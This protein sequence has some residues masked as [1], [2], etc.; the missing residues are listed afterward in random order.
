MGVG[1][2]QSRRGVQHGFRLFAANVFW[3]SLNLIVSYGIAFVTSIVVARSLGPRGAGIVSYLT[4]LTDTG[5]L[6]TGLG[7][8]RALERFL[9]E[10]LGGGRPDLLSPVLWQCFTAIFRVSLFTGVLCALIASWSLSPKGEWHPGYF[11]IVPVLVIGGALWVATQAASRGLYDFRSL[12]AAVMVRALGQLLLWYILLNLGVS[13][14]WLFIVH[15][16]LTAVTLLYVG[17]GNGMWRAMRGPRRDPDQSQRIFEYA[18]RVSLVVIA[19]VIVWQRSELFFLARYADTS[20]MAFFSIAAGF[21]MVITRLPQGITAVLFPVFARRRGQGR[22]GEAKALFVMSTRWI[23][24]VS[25]PLAV[26]AHS[27]VE[28]AVLFMYGQSF[29]DVAPLAKILVWSAAVA[30][31]GSPAAS[32]LYTADK[33][34]FFVLL[35]P[36]SIVINVA[37]AW[38]LC[39]RLG[40]LGAA[41]ANM[42]S[43]LFVTSTTLGYLWLKEKLSLPIV[44]LL[45][46]SALSALYFVFCRHLSHS[47]LLGFVGCIVLAGVYLLALIALGVFREELKELEGAQ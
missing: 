42:L 2:S 10:R 22:S 15:G 4:W 31:M 14:L 32:Y 30:P 37:L 11:L 18:M 47:G 39:W 24:A 9:S 19:D 33:E 1:Q 7:Y 35:A 23:C 12:S 13:L 17:S 29:S 25:V 38:V 5:A 43:Q 46:I 34:R 3:H 26:L 6:L 36:I 20:S 41:W 21:S 16:C 44:D 45:R 40:A 8:V 28:P 27:F